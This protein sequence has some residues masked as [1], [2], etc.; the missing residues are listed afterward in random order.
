MLTIRG[1]NWQKKKEFSGTLYENGK[2]SILGISDNY[3]NSNSRS[4]GVL[5]IDTVH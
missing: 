3:F 4:N 5:Y 1:K 2:Y